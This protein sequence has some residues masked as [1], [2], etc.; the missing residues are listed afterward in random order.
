[1][2]TAKSHRMD[3]VTEAIFYA[4]AGAAVAHVENREQAQTEAHAAAMK[5]LNIKP[6]GDHKPA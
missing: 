3:A 5:A 2:S 1:M 6:A 4:M